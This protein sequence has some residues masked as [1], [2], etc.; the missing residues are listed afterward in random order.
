[1]T[2][3]QFLP[4]PAARPDLSRPIFVRH[5]LTATQCEE[6]RASVEQGGGV[7]EASRVSNGGRGSAEDQAREYRLIRS[8]DQSNPGASVHAL[9]ESHVVGPAR[10]VNDHHY[11]FELTGV[12]PHDSIALLR[13]EHGQGGHFA[14]HRDLGPAFST[15][16]LSLSVQ[17]SDPTDYLGGDLI[18][19]YADAKA[20]RGIGTLAVFPSYLPHAVSPVTGGCR[21]ALV[22][23]IHGPAFR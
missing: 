13:Y 8:A 7:W 20:P 1:M 22:G 23:W 21:Y 14:L 2:F 11:S 15:R 9:L 18:F 19:P 3:A 16:K 10:L 6:I 17:L 4:L 5:A 12:L